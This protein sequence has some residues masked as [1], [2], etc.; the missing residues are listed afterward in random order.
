MICISDCNS[1]FFVFIVLYCIDEVLTRAVACWDKYLETKRLLHNV[2]C[3][4]DLL[5]SPLFSSCLKRKQ[6]GHRKKHNW[7]APL[8][9]A[10]VHILTGKTEDLYRDDLSLIKRQEGGWERRTVIR[11]EFDWIFKQVIFG[12][13]RNVLGSVLLPP[14]MGKPWH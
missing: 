2:K 10:I 6:A 4:P 13:I 11:L 1:T 5:R 9:T 7:T 3:Q 8:Q 12:R 14:T